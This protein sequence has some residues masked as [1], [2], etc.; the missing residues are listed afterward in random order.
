M[1]I[2]LYI[3]EEE[4][5]FFFNNHKIYLIILTDS[6]RWWKFSIFRLYIY[7]FQNKNQNN[8]YFHLL[9]PVSLFHVES[10]EDGK[11]EHES[12][13]FLYE[14]ISYT[15]PRI[16]PKLHTLNIVLNSQKAIRRIHSKDNSQLGISDIENI[17]R[18][19]TAHTHITS[20]TV[21]HHIQVT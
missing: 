9:T 18:W 13:P 12:M 14:E 15:P 11:I 16:Y 8:Q 2:I 4:I 19:N 7:F 10:N 3:N 21:H 6:D 17:H 20:A 5:W 1:C